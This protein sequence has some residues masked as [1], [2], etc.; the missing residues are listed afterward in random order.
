MELRNLR[1]AR[2]AAGVFATV[3]IAAVLWGQQANGSREGIALVT[4]WSHH[5][6]VYSNQSATD[7]RAPLRQEPRY[8]QQGL[9][10]YGKQWPTLDRLPEGAGTRRVKPRKRFKRD[11]AMSLGPGATV[12]AGQYPAKFSFDVTKA[13]CS[14]DFVAFNTGVPG[15]ATQASLVAFSNLYSGCSGTVPATYW[16]YNTGGT[17]L[18]SVAFSLDGNQF[19]F[20]QSSAG[21]A[22]LVLLKWKAST[23]AT[24]TSPDPITLVSASQYPTCTLPCTTTLLFSG[25]ANDTNSAPYYDYSDDVLYAGDDSGTLHKFTPVFTAGAPSEVTTGGWPVALAPGL[26]LSSPV[27]DSGTGR[28][29]VGSG[30]SGSG[31]QL[32]AVVGA[33][34]ATVG[35][36]SSLGKGAGIASGP[37]VDSSTGEVFVFVGNDGTSACSGPCSAVYQFAANFTSGAGVK[38]TVGTGGTFPLYAGDFDNAYF[39]SA[40]GTGSLYV[41]GWGFAAPEPTIFRVP[42]NSGAMSTSSVSGPAVGL[43]NTPC[44]PVTEVFNPAA[45]G[46]DRIFASVPNGSDAAPCSSGACINNLVIGAWQPAT[47]YTVGQSILDPANYW[48]VVATAGTSKSGTAPSWTDTCGVETSDSTVIW[49]NA[50]FLTPVT[51]TGWQAD[52]FYSVGFRITDSN[53]NLECALETGIHSGSSPPV[54]NTAIGGVTNDSGLQWR[55]GG[56]LPSHGLP[57]AAGTS[58]IIMDNIVGSGTLAGASQVYFSTLGTGGCGAGNGCAVQ[59]SQSGLN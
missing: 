47:S 11:W 42:I 29:F 16:A 20:V 3:G 58:G 21:Q 9:R 1:I 23:T 8:W 33:T 6:L 22:Q 40:N 14:G 25:G 27:P 10:R 45:G 46:T 57:V 13:S 2:R 50:G 51:A 5:H 54:W 52:A 39:S 55:N 53:N 18:T 48:Q 43:S 15:S 37:I 4:D 56:P 34:G 28:V 19:A 49:V 30:F 36:S 31:S 38:A 12:G 7:L 44:S 35:T 59:A 17:A 32:F 26:K 24:S 41:C